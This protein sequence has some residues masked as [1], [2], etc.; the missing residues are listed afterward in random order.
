MGD[1]NNPT[2]EVK[3]KSLFTIRRRVLV[4]FKKEF[5]IMELSPRNRVIREL[6]ISNLKGLSVIHR[7]SQ[8]I[9][10][11]LWRSSGRMNQ[12]NFKTENDQLKFVRGVVPLYK[13]LKISAPLQG[14]WKPIIAEPKVPA[15]VPWKKRILVITVLGASGDLA[16]KKIYPVLWKLF[17]NGHLDDDTLLIGY[18]R[19][20]LTQQ[21]LVERIQPY[22]EIEEGE[23]KKF[24]QFASMCDYFSGTYD[25]GRSFKGFNDYINQRVAEKRATGSN[26]LFY[27][28]LPPSVFEDVT[29]HLSKHCVTK[30]SQPDSGWTRVIV[31]KPFG[32]DSES[33]AKLDSHLSAL[34]CEDQIYRIDHYLGKEMVQNILPLR[35]ANSIFA[36]LFHEKHVQCVII[37]FKEDI[38]TW[39]RGGY[40]DSYGIIR[41]VMQNHLLQLLTLIAMEKPI[42][43]SAESIRNEK[44]RLLK[45]IDTLKLEDVILGQYVGAKVEGIEESDKGYRDDPTVPDDSRTPTY[46]CAVFRVRTERWDNVPFIIKCGKALNERKCEIRVQFKEQAADIFSET[47]RNELVMRV[48]PQEAVYMKM[49]VKEPGMSFNAHV[50][51]LDLTYAHKFKT[52]SKP[53]AYER[54]VRD[55]IEGSANNFVRRDELREAWRIFTPLLHAIDNGEIDPIPYDFGSR[56]PKETDELATKCGYKY[57]KRQ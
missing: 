2:F 57:Y 7:D 36:P 48:Q 34:L 21:A 16:K 13:K 12:F 32:N 10:R 1:C 17:R 52:S 28:A 24:E 15:V 14:N 26:R 8:F 30:A 6:P 9:V 19:S 22:L 40:F 20:K 41:D 56:G 53:D 39:G 4:I 50:T 29:T 23:E 38:G 47:Q 55:C 54:L 51:D 45:C 5:K 35:F 18:A 42:T 43:Q 25:D 3:K 31:E 33:F 49:M 44:V 27:L 46:A 11:L 37:N